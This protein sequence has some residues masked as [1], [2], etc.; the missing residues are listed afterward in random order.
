MN[1]EN[2]ERAIQGASYHREAETKLL[3]PECT[4]GGRA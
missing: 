2:N 1:V 3:A 4:E